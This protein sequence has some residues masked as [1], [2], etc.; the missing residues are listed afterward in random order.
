MGGMQRFQD[1]RK[2]FFLLCAK[3]QRLQIGEEYLGNEKVLIV[4]VVFSE[5]PDRIN[6]FFCR[7]GTITASMTISVRP[8]QFVA[9]MDFFS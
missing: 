7:S 2:I 4:S 9:G 5:N 6:A 8:F 3:T 1:K